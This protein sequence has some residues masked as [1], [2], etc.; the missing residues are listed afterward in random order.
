MPLVDRAFRASTRV[1]G[2]IT[3]VLGLV[4]IAVTL[5]RGGGPLAL[6]VVAG[7][8]FAVV[9]VLRFIMATRKG[10]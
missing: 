2:A 8:L 10:T 3:F 9:G 4:M 6:G 1:L 5:G 7:V